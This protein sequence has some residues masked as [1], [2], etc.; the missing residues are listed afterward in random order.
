M[1][2]LNILC[3]I[4]HRYEEQFTT[5]YFCKR[6]LKTLLQD[7]KESFWTQLVYSS[8]SAFQQ[9]WFIKL[10]LTCNQKQCFPYFCQSHCFSLDFLSF[11]TLFL[12]DIS[13]KDLRSL[14]FPILSTWLHFF[15]FRTLHLLNL[16]H[17][18]FHP[19]FGPFLQ[20]VRIIIKLLSH[21]T[22]CA[23]SF[24]ALYYLHF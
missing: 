12:N 13:A 10:F 17:A 15:I 9:L 16:T 8:P 11:C 5:L 18:E 19:S 6:D 24:L 3:P 23:Q 7:F 1:S 4:Y 22:A 14:L 20:L 21:P 2:F